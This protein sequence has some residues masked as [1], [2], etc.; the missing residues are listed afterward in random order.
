MTA[1][2]P[3][4][5]PR[6]CKRQ[7]NTTSR[8]LLPADRY[9]VR[10]P[11]LIKERSAALEACSLTP[12]HTIHVPCGPLK[13]S[14][15]HGGT[16][17]YETGRH[18]LVPPSRAPARNPT[19]LVPCSPHFWLQ[20]CATVDHWCRS[21]QDTNKWGTRSIRDSLCRASIERAIFNCCSR[22]QMLHSTVALVVFVIHLDYGGLQE[23]TS[24]NYGGLPGTA[25]M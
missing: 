12:R 21:G 14:Q 23:A 3:P 16:R 6:L 9:V 24:E 17:P 13:N 7:S 5:E 22:R 2:I 8:A 19:F 20:N 1:A 25:R 18:R 15:A 4:A 11:Q 10:A